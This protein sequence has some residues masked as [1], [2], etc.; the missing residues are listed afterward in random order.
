MWRLG[1][2]LKAA[3]FLRNGSCLI[4]DLPGESISTEPTLKGLGLVEALSKSKSFSI[5]LSM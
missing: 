5:A 1:L 2:D 4:D 3:E